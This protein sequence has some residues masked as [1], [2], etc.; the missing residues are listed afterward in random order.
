MDTIKDLTLLVNSH[1]TT[2]L[3][4]F[5]HFQLLATAC[6]FSALSV[7]KQPVWSNKPFITWSL[8]LLVVMSGIMVGQLGNGLW[9]WLMD[10]LRL[11][12][13]IPVDGRFWLWLLALLNS[14]CAIG[15]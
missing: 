6:A 1:E 12:K 9:E 5:L 14:A 8:V 7:Y 15:W 10:V 3:W 11:R 13:D 2:I 4:S